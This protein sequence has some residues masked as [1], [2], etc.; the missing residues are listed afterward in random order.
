MRTFDFLYNADGKIAE[1]KD[2]VYYPT[3][4]WYDEPKIVTLAGYDPYYTDG[5]PDPKNADECVEWCQIE[6]FGDVEDSQIRLGDLYELEKY[7]G[8]ASLLYNGWEIEIIGTFGYIEEE[9]MYAFKVGDVLKFEDEVE[10]EERQELSDLNEEQLEWFYKHCTH[11]SIFLSDYQN[12]LG[13]EVHEASNI[14]ELWLDCIDND[15]KENTFEEFKNWVE[16][17]GYC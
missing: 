10:L 8:E 6:V 3:D 2:V 13:I 14:A 17:G 16:I 1:G 15:E 7:D 12:S 9:T 4:N 5:S 11:G